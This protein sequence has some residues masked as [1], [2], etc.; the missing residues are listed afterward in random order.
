MGKLYY[1]NEQYEKALVHLNLWKEYLETGQHSW[2]G[3]EPEEEERAKNNRR[4]I[5]VHGLLARIYRLNGENGKPDDF[6]KVLACINKTRTGQ[7][8]L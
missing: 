2:K 4:M 6:E 8:L 7:Q 5:T 3:T 1:T